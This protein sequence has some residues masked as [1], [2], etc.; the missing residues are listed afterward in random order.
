MKVPRF[1][2]LSAQEFFSFFKYL[3]AKPLSGDIG[4]RSSGWTQGKLSEELDVSERQ[5]RNYLSGKSY[6]PAVMRDKIFQLFFNSD[7]DLYAKAYAEFGRNE[8]AMPA[9]KEENSAFATLTKHSS[10]ELFWKYI[11]DH[12]VDITSI[13]TVY[14]STV[15]DAAWLMQNYCSNM[16][17]DRARALA[18]EALRNACDVKYGDW[19]QERD[20]R[21]THGI[22]RWNCE[23][24]SIF[25]EYGVKRENRLI[26][27]GVG[28]GLE[29]EGIYG[30]F[31]L[32]CGVD[33]SEKALERARRVFPRMRTEAVSAEV[34]SSR[35]GKFDVYIS[36][37][38]YQSSFFMIKESIRKCH[39][40]LV[41]GG[42]A[43]VSIPRG[44]YDSDGD[45]QPGLAKSNYDL[46][47]CKEFGNY[48]I[49]D[50]RYPFELIYTLAGE[51][52]FCG[53]FDVVVRT[54]L[55]EHYVIARR[56]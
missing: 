41:P 44:Y 46:K 13:P 52:E 4:A 35:Y 54:G 9:K 5:I 14:A 48:R 19:K 43:I 24:K 8:L 36:L 45:R 20:E 23:L 39:E 28:C 15:D 21:H 40:L 31:S 42:V 3:M 38:T 51:M 27:V 55:Y 29:G 37:R 47:S 25:A 34:I 7:L 1:N 22:E 6:P 2:D 11:C 26:C 17:M 30:D 49:I 18:R 16:D 53:F 12:G 32:F 33:V 56:R 50:L 10:T